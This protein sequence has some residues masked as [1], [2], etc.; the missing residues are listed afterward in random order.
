LVY[1]IASRGKY[2]FEKA[3]IDV[4]GPLCEIHVFDFSGSYGASW[5]L[6][7]NVHFHQWWLKSSHSPPTV[8]L[9]ENLFTFQEIKC[10][11][12]H[13]ERAI[14]IFKI[15]CEDSEWEWY[16]QSSKVCCSDVLV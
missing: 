16:V 10:K 6:A 14:D 15:D 3:V 12:G 11:L 4:L 7:K 9:E 5:Q 2:I 13:K 1:S 8:N